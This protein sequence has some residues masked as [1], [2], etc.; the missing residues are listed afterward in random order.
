LYGWKVVTAMAEKDG[1]VQQCELTDRVNIF[2]ALE[3]A[4]IDHLGVDDH[5]VIVIYQRAI[6]M[7][8]VTDGRATAAQAADIELWNPPAN[9]PDRNPDEL[10]TAFVAE[11]VAAA[12]TTRVDE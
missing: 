11:L 12:D 10:L 9:D 1:P 5:R 4:E 2:T 3:T 6:L 7:V 8:V